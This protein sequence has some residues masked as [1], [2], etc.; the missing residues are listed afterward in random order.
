[1]SENVPP[2]GS[3][4]EREAAELI[5]NLLQEHPLPEP[6]YI[7]PT[8]Q[9]QEGV[10]AVGS[11]AA[12]TLNCVAIVRNGKIIP[13]I[14][15]EGTPEPE[16]AGEKMHLFA[17]TARTIIDGLMDAL[18]FWEARHRQERNEKDEGGTC[19]V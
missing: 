1:M 4:A 18:V 16:S 14:D 15:L 19:R 6:R 17:L 8:G 11:E 5:T 13:M 10:Y 9:E 12:K 2:G 3:H 7:D